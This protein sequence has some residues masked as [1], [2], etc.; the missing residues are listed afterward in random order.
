MTHS[1]RAALRSVAG[2]VYSQLDNLG[3]DVI[4]CDTGGTTFDVGL[5]RDGKLVFTRESWLG[6]QWTGHIVSMSTVDVRS[7]GAG[8]GSTKLV[9]P[10]KNSTFA[11][12]ALIASAK[13][14]SGTEIRGFCWLEC[15]T[16]SKN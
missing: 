14:F 16:T 5:V 11:P 13:T 9:P 12:A 6:L 7:V 4:V 15:G 10:T 1:M 2:R 8:G 3:D